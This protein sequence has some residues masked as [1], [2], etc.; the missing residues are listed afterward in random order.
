MRDQ[1]VSKA[2]MLAIKAFQNFRVINLCKR[3]LNLEKPRNVT[4]IDA[5]KPY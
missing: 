3:S 2:Q 4:K 1:N 5:Q